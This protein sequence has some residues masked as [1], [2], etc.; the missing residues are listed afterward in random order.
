MLEIACVKW[1]TKY[2]A[3]WVNRLARAAARNLSQPHRIVCFTDRPAGVECATEPLPPY[4]L[5]GW[6]NKVWLFSLERDMLYLDIDV[7]ILGDI[8]PMAAMPWFTICK[9]PWQAGYNSSVMKITPGLAFVWERFIR[10][11]PDL[12]R[13]MHGDQD[14]INLA[15]PKAELFEPGWCLSYKAHARA[16]PAALEAA[17]VVYFHGEPKQDKAPEDWIKTHWI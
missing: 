4:S 14:F 5:N 6:W 11:R 12:P 17:R 2:P 7:V 13:R 1:G 10:E 16:Y 3:D 8:T 9:D 15:L